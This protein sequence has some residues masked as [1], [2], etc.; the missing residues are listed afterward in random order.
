MGLV[1]ILIVFVAIA[2]LFALQQP[3]FLGADEKAHL[4]YAHDVAARLAADDRRTAGRSPLWAD[5]WMAES[6]YTQVD[7]NRTIWVANH[8]PLFYASVAPL[9]W[10]SEFTHRPDGGLLLLRLANIAYGAIGVAFTY[11]IAL[12]LTRSSRIALA[13]DRRRRDDH[14]V[15]RRPVVGDERRLDV[16]RR[17]RGHVGGIAMP[18][19]EERRRGT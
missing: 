10:Y 17:C 11:A 12:Q 13:V 1:G 6:I 4:A 5:Q 7:A 19:S 8:P 14:P 15:V 16:R 2:T 18:A 3:P 9:I